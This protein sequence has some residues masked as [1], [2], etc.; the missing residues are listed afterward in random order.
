MPIVRHFEAQAVRRTFQSDWAAFHERSRVRGFR[1]FAPTGR[2]VVRSTWR[3]WAEPHS[4]P[5]PAPE[6]GGAKRAGLC[7]AVYTHRKLI[8]SCRMAYPERAP[9]SARRSASDAPWLHSPPRQIGVVCGARRPTSVRTRQNGSPSICLPSPPS[10]DYR[11]PGV[12]RAM[13]RR[14][15]TPRFSSAVAGLLGSTLGGESNSPGRFTPA[16]RHDDQSLLTAFVAPRSGPI[17]AFPLCSPRTMLQGLK[18]AGTAGL[19]PA[20]SGLTVRCSTN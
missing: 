20:T 15:V 16:T 13:G 10:P 11:P 8:E 18:L 7:A 4:P 19:E 12:V 1:S 14:A 5:C 3:D 6:A 2:Y 17:K 9:R